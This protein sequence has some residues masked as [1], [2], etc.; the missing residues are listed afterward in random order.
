TAYDVYQQGQFVKSVDGNT[1]S[2][3]VTKLTPTASY[4]FYVNARDGAGNV[5]QASNTVSVTTPP[6]VVDHQPPTVPGNVRLSTV[7]ANSVALVWDPATDNV[8]V[9][10]YTVYRGGTPVATATTNAA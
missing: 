8:G 5:S 4:G 7:T 2:T 9:T 10:G 1:F 3:T 6:S